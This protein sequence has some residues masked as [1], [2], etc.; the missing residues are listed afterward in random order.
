MMSL[1]EVKPQSASTPMTCSGSSR[2]AAISTVEAVKRCRVPVIFFHGESDDYVPCEMSREN[3]DACAS[4]KALVTIP[5]AGHG[6][7]YPAAPET[8]LEAARAFFGSEASCQ[9][10]KG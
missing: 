6:L 3:Y 1:A 4:R 8:Y 5:G 10:M 7:S 2:P 9:T